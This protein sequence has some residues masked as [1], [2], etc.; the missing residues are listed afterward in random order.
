M[1]LHINPFSVPVP[2][3]SD[4]LEGH[5]LPQIWRLIF[6]S[7]TLY[8]VFKGYIMYYFVLKVIFYTRISVFEDEGS[9]FINLAHHTK[10]KSTCFLYRC[11]A[12]QFFFPD[13]SDLL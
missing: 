4:I 11:D 13:Y 3:G 5:N 12:D 9:A 8:Y 2:P 1:F 10:Q 7:L 6:L